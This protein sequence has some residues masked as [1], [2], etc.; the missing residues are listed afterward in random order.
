MPTRKVAGRGN[1]SA[2]AKAKQ[3]RKDIKE[4]LQIRSNIWH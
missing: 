2:E 1:K 3:L 4:K